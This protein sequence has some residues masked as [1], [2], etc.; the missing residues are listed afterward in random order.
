MAK[1]VNQKA[2]MMWNCECKDQEE[3]FKLA[4]LKHSL[5]VQDKKNV[6]TQMPLK[7]AEESALPQGKVY[8]KIIDEVIRFEEPLHLPGDQ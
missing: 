2:F 6:M 5:E 3:K 1:V 7:M 4:G 8:P